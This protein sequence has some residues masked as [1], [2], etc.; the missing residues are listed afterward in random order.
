M[1]MAALETAR[2]NHDAA[3]EWLDTAF[4][5]RSG[6]LAFINREPSLEPLRQDPRFAALVQKLGLTL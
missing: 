2:N 3:F 6:W 1:V 5:E 4:E